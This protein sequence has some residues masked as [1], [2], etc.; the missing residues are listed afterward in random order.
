LV[1]ALGHAVGHGPDP[2]WLMAAEMSWVNHSAL[3][4]WW[5]TWMCYPYALGPLCLG[6]IAIAIRYPAW[7]G[8]IAF[9]LLALLLA[10][11][12]ADLLQ[13]LFA[14]PRRLDWVVKHETAFS[15]PS[16][17]AAIVAGFYG[18]LALLVAR[19]A[20]R[21][22]AIVAGAIGLLGLAILWSRL[23]LGA[24]YLTDLAGGVLWG[25]AVVA[26]LAAC[27]PRNVFEGRS[28]STL[29]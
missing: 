19:S 16:S 20:L 26:A 5:L 22:R 11:R 7:R 18:V 8:R 6:L 1:L 4:A 28:R 21:S 13:H 2:A 24:H 17:H 9:A 14:R 12:G 25:G 3:L 10:W 29:E 23:A 27:W 15:F